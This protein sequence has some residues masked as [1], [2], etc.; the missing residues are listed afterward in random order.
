MFGNVVLEAMASGLALVA[1]DHAAAQE[2]VVN[3]VSG[4]VVPPSDARGFITSAYQLGLDPATRRML[5]ANAR[6]AA[7]RC[8]PDMV[9]SEFEALLVSLLH[10]NPDDRL[11]A[12]A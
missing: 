12:V 3:G 6:R 10:G 5:G 1:F 4:L 2:H 7:L 11:R 8:P 9:I